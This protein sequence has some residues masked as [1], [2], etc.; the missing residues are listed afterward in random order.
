MTDT[1][2][3]PKFSRYVNDKSTF[4]MKSLSVRDFMD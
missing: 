1:Y 2:S 3:M 4:Y